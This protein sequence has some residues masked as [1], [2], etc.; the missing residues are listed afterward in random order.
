VKLKEALKISKHADIVESRHIGLF[1]RLIM[2]MAIFYQWHTATSVNRH[3]LQADDEYAEQNHS[4]DGLSEDALLTAGHGTIISRPLVPAAH[5]AQWT[6]VAFEAISC[7]CRNTQ[8]WSESDLSQ[9]KKLYHHIS[10]LLIIPLQPMCDHIGWMS[11]KDRIEKARESLCAWL[12][13]DIQNART[14]VMHAVAL[15]CLIR[16]MK[17]GAHSESHHLFVAFLTIW[18]FFSLD[19]VARPRAGAGE[20]S[21]VAPVCCIDWQGHVSP[22]AKKTWIQAPGHP[23]LRIAGLGNLEEP[24]GIH[25]ILVETH[26]VLLSDQVWGTSHLFATVLEDLISRGTAINVR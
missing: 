7:I 16:K 4:L 14:A 9:L 10:I 25:R 13:S 3:I 23:T 1:A 8:T 22:E 20:R 2:M 11:T 5:R 18:T 17:S 15:F 6:T 21:W 26:R 24:S 19:P 12:R